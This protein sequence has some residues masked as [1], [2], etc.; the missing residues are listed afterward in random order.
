[1]DVDVSG[2]IYE[3]R[4]LDCER[5]K[6]SSL[7]RIRVQATDTLIHWRL[8]RRSWRYPYVVVLHHAGSDGHTAYSSYRDCARDNAWTEFVR[9][10]AASQQWQSERRAAKQ[11]S[12]MR[13]ALWG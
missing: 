9:Q 7:E 13:Q 4:T 12:E 5:V 8:V 2:R 1:M 11:G 3:K 6:S 10:N